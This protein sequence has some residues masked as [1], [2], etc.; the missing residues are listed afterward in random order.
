MLFVVW[1]L[2][3]YHTSFG[4]A[5]HTRFINLL[6]PWWN[7]GRPIAHSACHVTLLWSLR[8]TSRHLSR[9]S[10]NS[11]ILMR[12]QMFWGL[13]LLRFPCDCTLRPTQDC[14]TWNSIKW[15][16]GKL[17]CATGIGNILSRLLHLYYALQIKP[18][19]TRLT[20]FSVPRKRSPQQQ[21]KDNAY[22]T[23]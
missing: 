3:C 20:E 22:M 16:C 13:P 15:P 14:V 19:I 10:S 4:L 9:L 2:I 6:R 12:H 17:R 1:W 21:H 7:T 8:F 5:C 23:W 18:T 11:T